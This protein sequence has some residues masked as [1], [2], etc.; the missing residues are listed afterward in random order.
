VKTEYS[1]STLVDIFPYEA[2]VQYKTNNTI[3][4]GFSLL[5]LAIILYTVY[6][7]LSH[8]LRILKRQLIAKSLTPRETAHKL[9]QVNL[10]P[11][12]KSQLE[13]IRFAR[14]EPTQQQVLDLLYRIR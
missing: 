3:S 10:Q 7:Y 2:A 9:S 5:A 6:R 1:S 14:T 8:P 12:L 11:S 13:T 4:I